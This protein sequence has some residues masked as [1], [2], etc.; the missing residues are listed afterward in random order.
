MLKKAGYFWGIVG[1]IVGMFAVTVWAGSPDVLSQNDVRLYRRALK[2]Y[3]AA[4]IKTGDKAAGQIKDDSLKGYLLYTKYFSKGYRTKANQVVQWL[5]AYGDLPLAPDMYAL[6]EQKKAKLPK[7]KPKGIFGGASGSCSYVAREDPIDLLSGRSFSYLNGAKRKQAVRDMAQIAR[8]LRRGKTLN[9]KRLIESDT[10]RQRFSKTDWDAARTALA[11]SY[12]LDGEN[13]QALSLSRA[14]LKRSA[15]QFPQA[16]WTAGLVSWRMNQTKDAADYFHQ[17]LIHPKVYPLLQ[18]SAAFWEARARLKLGQFEQVGDLLEIAAKHQRT[19][20]GILAMRLLGRDLRHVWDA[21]PRPEDDMSADFSHP[22]LNRFYALKQIGRDEWAARELS[23]VYLES[24]NQSKSIL[25]MISEQN[26]FADELVMIS[27]KLKNDNVRYPAPNWTPKDGWQADKALVFAFV[28]QESCFNT[29]AKSAVGALGL[30]QIMPQTGRE[31]ARLLQYPW[32]L[33][34]LNDPAYNLSLGQN[35]LLRL[36][37]RPEIQGNLMF[38]ALSYN[39]GPGNL[40]K[41]KKKMDFKDD[42]LLFLESIP[43]R[44]TRGFVERI[45]V[46]YWIYRSLMEQPLVS[47]DETVAGRWP[48][49]NSF[50][51]QE[52]ATKEALSGNVVK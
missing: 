18:A 28:L 24:D 23:K 25:L 10:V 11:F 20:Y 5:N 37:K 13:D 27:G 44:E 12:F 14:V 43:S 30:M 15:S 34:R 41:W 42:P 21:P 31:L 2:A 39:A 3:E 16:A 6:G 22:A 29:R 49:Y 45:M 52:S 46:N 32:S 36:M 4:D 8:Y 47:L 50:E 9:A 17:A 40:I 38:T 35:Y 19:F 26:D 48:I 1:L 7:R 51:T 33:K